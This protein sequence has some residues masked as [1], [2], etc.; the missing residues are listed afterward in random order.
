MGLTALAYCV[1]I[2]SLVN[3]YD[4]RPTAENK[5]VLIEKLK[6][7]EID[8]QYRFIRQL[9]LKIF[10]E[11]GVNFS[12]VLKREIAKICLMDTKLMFT[13]EEKRHVLLCFYS[14]LGDKF[15]E[16][17]N[18][19][20]KSELSIKYPRGTK[21]KLTKTLDDKYNPIREGTIFV[22]D[23]VDD[24]GS[25]HGTWENGSTIAVIPDVDEFEVIE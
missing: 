23:F 3:S 14:M 12:D 5:A 15:F 13:E 16:I 24:I 20:R 21:I 18:I 25:I 22:V 4:R 9:L 6:E 10:S 2:E 8:N 19:D 1:S 17:F 11:S 7:H